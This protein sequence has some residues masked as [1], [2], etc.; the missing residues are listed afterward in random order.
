MPAAAM[1]NFVLLQRWLIALIK[2]GKTL[3]DKNE[4]GDRK[5]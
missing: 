2:N 1:W 4:Y 3:I 5:I